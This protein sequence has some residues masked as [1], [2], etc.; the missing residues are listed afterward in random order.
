MYEINEKQRKFAINFIFYII[1]FIIVCCYGITHTYAYTYENIGYFNDK[2]SV[3]VEVNYTS[4]PLSVRRDQYVQ[5]EQVFSIDIFLDNINLAG[6]DIYQFEIY[7]PGTI[8]TRANRGEVYNNTGNVSVACSVLSTDFTNEYPQLRFQCPGNTNITSLYIRYSNASNQYLFDP[9]VWHWNYTYL[10][11]QIGGSS[12]G[13]D[14]GEITDSIESS[15]KSIINNNNKNTQ[16][17]I[18][19][20]NQNTQQIIESNQVCENVDKNNSEINGY[21]YNNGTVNTSDTTSIVTEYFKIDSST[22]IIKSQNASNDAY[23]RLCFYDSNKSYIS[24]LTKDNYNSLEQITVPTNAYYVRFTINKSTNLP[25]FKICQNGNQAITD[26]VNG[27]TSA[28]TD[29]SPVN[30][31]SLGNTAGWLPPGPIDSIINLPLNLLNNL[32]TAL[33]KTCAPINIPLPYVNRNLPIP[34][35]STIF[36][37]ITGLPAFWNWVGVITSVVILYR[38]LIA[39]YKYYDDLT[40][41]KA[42]FISDFG[43]AP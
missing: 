37:Q 11:R 16:N 15:T 41:L 24:C 25:Q 6:N 19:N 18:N 21:L 30:I 43:G 3:Q 42:N 4:Q 20:N 35:I 9:Q 34:C 38:Y 1:T 13:S 17:I 40:T 36:N 26:S 23:Y 7:T 12:D 39:L 28:L 33:N 14:T 5:L 31:D 8:L 10:R 22:K 32:M 2:T 27:L 29:D